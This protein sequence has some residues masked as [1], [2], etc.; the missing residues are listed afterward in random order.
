MNETKEKIL[1][2]NLLDVYLGSDIQI[3]FDKDFDHR[4][5]I[6]KMVFGFNYRLRFKFIQGDSD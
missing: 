5:H 4:S 1:E 2:K 3:D 6:E